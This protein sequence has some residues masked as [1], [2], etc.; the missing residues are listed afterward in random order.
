MMSRRTPARDELNPGVW[1]LFE[2]QLVTD[3]TE[4]QCAE[5]ANCTPKL[6]FCAKY[7]PSEGGTHSKAMQADRRICENMFPD[8]K[9][10]AGNVS[11]HHVG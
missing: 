7:A 9:A 8:A 1:S 5:K 6:L 3:W 4:L 2:E 10:A 11:W